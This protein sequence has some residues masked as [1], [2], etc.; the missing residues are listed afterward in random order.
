MA[1]FL[2]FGR[3]MLEREMVRRGTQKNPDMAAKVAK[4]RLMGAPMPSMAQM[5]GFGMGEN[6]QRQGGMAK[7][8]GGVN[9]AAGGSR[10]TAKQEPTAGKRFT[11][12][13]MFGMRR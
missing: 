11:L 1:G 12:R 6:A 2:G 7:V 9:R 3:K 4:M 8:M 10:L 13:D 5:M